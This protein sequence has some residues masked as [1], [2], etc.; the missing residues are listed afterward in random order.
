MTLNL[1]HD[2]QSVLADKFFVG[3]H[4]PYLVGKPIQD[5]ESII[6]AR[7]LKHHDN[8]SDTQIFINDLV[9]YLKKIK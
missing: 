5:T 2:N 1:L 9:E 6:Y 4:I 7:Y 8:N 3:R